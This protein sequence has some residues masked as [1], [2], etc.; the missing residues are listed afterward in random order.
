[1]ERYG[2]DPAAFFNREQATLW[3]RS[4]WGAIGNPDNRRLRLLLNWL[5]V[6]FLVTSEEVR[7]LA[8]T[9][10]ADTGLSEIAF[11]FSSAVRRA[12]Y[13]KPRL[14]SAAAYFLPLPAGCT[15]L[16]LFDVSR[17]ECFSSPVPAWSEV[18]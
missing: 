6:D 12:R 2:F 1:M 10:L 4:Y 14:A 7:A 9:G 5:S 8:L 13:D 11:S 3:D 15:Q 18:A 17:R 16:M